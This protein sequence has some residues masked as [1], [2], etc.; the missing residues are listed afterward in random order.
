MRPKAMKMIF[1]IDE[2]LVEKYSWQMTIERFTQIYNIMN[3]HFL[4]IGIKLVLLDI[5]I[6]KNKNSNLTLVEAD[7][8][9]NL[10][11]FSKWINQKRGA[12]WDNVDNVLLFLD[13]KHF[14]SPVVGKA[15]LGT[16]CTKLSV[17]VIADH[18]SI[19]EG[20]AATA[21]H[22]VG[23]N[24]G[25]NHDPSDD[26]SCVCVAGDSRCLMTGVI[27]SAY[28]QSWSQ[29]SINSISKLLLTH[30]CLH[31]LSEIDDPSRPSHVNSSSTSTLYFYILY[32]ICTYMQ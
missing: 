17:G 20:I 6:W 25:L 16:M 26:P 9:E 18:T 2:H 5:S 15:W 11:I 24:L 29:C 30:T 32:I 27:Y 1:V 10:K 14:K 7:S 4:Q 22:E 13:E 31:E 23:H 8:D 19:E 21:S 28:P 12:N 3:N